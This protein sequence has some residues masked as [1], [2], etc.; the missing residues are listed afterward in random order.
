MSHSE[1]DAAK[2]MRREAR[3]ARNN[4]AQIFDD[5]VAFVDNI[6]RSESERSAR[7][8]ANDIRRGNLKVKPNA[9]EYAAMKRRTGQSRHPLIGHGAYANSIR[10]FRTGDMQ[11]AVGVKAGRHPSGIPFERLMRILEAGTTDGI[12]AR[13]HFRQ[14]EK[15]ARKRLRGR[16]RKANVI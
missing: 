7:K 1:R 8:L 11:W 5:A 16:L 10:A 2:H 12:P 13:P 9:P 14:A 3:N 15:V 6:V 4:V